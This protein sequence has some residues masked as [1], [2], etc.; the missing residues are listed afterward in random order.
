MQTLINSSAPYSVSIFQWH[1]DSVWHNH[2][3]LEY[4][5][6]LYGCTVLVQLHCISMAI[7]ENGSEIIGKGMR[8]AGGAFRLAVF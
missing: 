7:Q 6:F 5:Y 3:R 8:G 4:T 2:I 1:Q